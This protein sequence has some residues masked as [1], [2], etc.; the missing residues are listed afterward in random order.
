MLKTKLEKATGSKKL[1]AALKL[2]DIKA[3]AEHFKVPYHTVYYI[4]SGRNKGD[5][6][7]VDCAKEIV[8][9]YQKVDMDKTV[10]SIIKSYEPTIKN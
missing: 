9:F 7:I 10:T 1:K 3:I 5:K 2:G 4:I 6:K 8:A